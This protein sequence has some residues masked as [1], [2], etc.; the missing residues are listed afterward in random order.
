MRDSR[1]RFW[2]ISAAALA[3]TAGTLAL[4]AWQLGRA[5]QRIALHEALLRQQ[6][7]APVDEQALLGG[8]P[9]A[10]L[11]QRAI[12][13]RGRWVPQRTIFLDNRQMDGK[14]GFY[15]VTPLVLQGSGKAVL[16]ERGWVQRHFE[17]RDEL[18]AVPSPAGVVTVRGRIAPPPAKLYDFGGAPTGAI[19]QNVDLPRFRAETGLPL[20]DLAVRQTGND[21]SDGLLRDWP[22]PA[23]GAETNYGY[24]FQ[25]W[26]LAAL[27]AI[28]Y[29]WF[30]FIAPR[31]NAPPAR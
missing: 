7:L 18:P 22:E 1:L 25:W 26:A 24:A 20:L 5:H 11:L 9:A 17:R 15:V 8:A 28:L 19:R 31:R 3:V 23:S 14:V 12:V 6:R 10:Q 4:G 30:Q 27:T 13:V 21:T 2:V 16:V 29:V